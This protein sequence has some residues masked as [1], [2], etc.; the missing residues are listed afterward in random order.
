MKKLFS[1][2]IL[3]GLCY[4][5]FAQQEYT[6]EEYGISFSLADDFIEITN[7]ADEFSASGDGMEISILPFKD[8]SVDNSDITAYTMGVAASMDFERIDD[9]DVIEFNG[10]HAAYAEGVLEDVK[11][12]FMGVIDPDTSTNFFI[13]I[14][15]LDNDENA[16][17]EAV[18]IC[19]GIRK[20]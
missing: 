19:S 5:G 4:F 1:I 9:I 12:F 15:F 13:I 7:N 8:D 17:N 2:I 3:T 10:F 11:V 18:N 16:I 6:W 20:L 14:T